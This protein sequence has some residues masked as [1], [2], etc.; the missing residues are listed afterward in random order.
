MERFS[1]IVRALVPLVLPSICT[2]LIHQAFQSTFG[3]NNLNLG[4][5]SRDIYIP[6]G[7]GAVFALYQMLAN[8]VSCSLRPSFFAATLV[9]LSVLI[10]VLKNYILITNWVPH[11]VAVI[12][13]LSGSFIL[14]VLSFFSTLKFSEVLAYVR[15]R[16]T[17]A[18]YILIALISL[19][20]YPLILKFFWR[21]ASYLTA[22]SV[23]WVYKF[24]GIDLLFRLTPVSFNLSGGGFA[25]KIIMGCSGLEGIFFFV[26]AFSLIQCLEKRG[27]NWKVLVAY[28]VGCLF[29]FLLNTVRISAFYF[30]GIQFEKMALGTTG[31]K[32]IEGAFHNHLGW[33]LYLMGIILFIRTYRELERKWAVRESNP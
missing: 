28:G 7:L 31:K 22:R 5:Y 9:F 14:L 25:I 33:I 6:L 1:K 19:L 24:F 30:L 10:L 11:S 4:I 3:S 23:Y 26:F 21:E 32:L 12:F 2:F 20:N 16:N 13:L 17:A 15:R 27:V 8:G 18:A 29:L